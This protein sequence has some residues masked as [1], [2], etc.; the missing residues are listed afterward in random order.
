MRHP[1]KQNSSMNTKD[2]INKKTT[3]K[4]KNVLSNKMNK[5]KLDYSDILE[6]APKEIYNNNNFD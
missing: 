1:G 4:N 6:H 5:E 2:N 3:G